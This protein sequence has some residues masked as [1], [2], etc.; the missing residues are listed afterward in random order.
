MTSRPF[1]DAIMPKK[2]KKPRARKTKKL[3]HP[4][5]RDENGLNLICQILG[6]Q[7]DEPVPAEYQDAVLVS[8]DF[9]NL[10]AFDTGNPQMPMPIHNFVSGSR[11]YHWRT[12]INFLFGKP[13]VTNPSDFLSVIQAHIPEDRNIPLVGHGIKNDLKVLKNIG[14]D[15]AQTRPASTL[16]PSTISNEFANGMLEIYRTLVQMQYL[17]ETWINEGPHDMTAWLTVCRI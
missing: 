1:H 9:E 16:S 4:S 5:S 15:M 2:P 6:L 11:N 8:I 7:D 10:Q 17:K 12:H 14:F 3:F 13:T